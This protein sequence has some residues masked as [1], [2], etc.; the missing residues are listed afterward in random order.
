VTEVLNGISREEQEVVFEEWL[1]RLDRCIQQNG[2]N[3][4]YGQFHKYILII[5][6]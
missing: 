1:L 3:V 2:G 6:A 5:S 4:E